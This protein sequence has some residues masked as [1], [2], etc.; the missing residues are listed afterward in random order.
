M[1]SSSTRLSVIIPLAPGENAW[2]DLLSD[3]SVLDSNCE[4]I[5]VG[6]ELP[7]ESE[8][9]IHLL[10]GARVIFLRSPLGRAK[11][12][13]LAAKESNANFLWFL[14]ADSR[15]HRASIEK[16]LQIISNTSNSTDLKILYYFDLKFLDDGPL[17]TTIN[18]A[19]VYLRCRLL[20]L[21]FGDQGY[22]L[23]KDMLAKLGGFPED[24]PYGEDH[25][26]IWKAKRSGLTI[27]STGKFI[28]TSARKYKQLGWLKTT[29]SH[30][31]LFLKQA[32]PEATALL[33]E[34]F[35]R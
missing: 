28:R 24:S 25:L 29:T 26:L 17:L 1:S 21:P 13:N 3:L 33:K 4:V 8:I 35:A 22:L 11:Q 2:K 14:H 16:T 23:P 10:S 20:G 6:P 19:G 12:M 7:T 34:R 27:K 32:M 30:L 9:A 5:L 18:S 31:Y 15:M